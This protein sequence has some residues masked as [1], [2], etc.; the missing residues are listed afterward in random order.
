MS[1]FLKYISSHRAPALFMIVSAAIF[2]TVLYL[3]SAPAEAVLYAVLL[4]LVVAAFFCFFSYRDYRRRREELRFFV[5]DE[6]LDTDNL[7]VPRHIMEQEYTDAIISL[8]DRLRCERTEYERRREEMVDYYTVWAHQIKTPL[9]AMNLILQGAEGIDGE[10]RSE[11]LK[12]EQYVDMV[13]AYL[14]AGG[15][16]TDFLIR[17]VSLGD[18]VRASVRRLSPIFIREKISANVDIGYVRVLTD[19]KWLAFAVEQLLTNA[20]KYTPAGGMITITVQN[21]D[22]LVIADTGIGISPEDLPRIFEKG[23]TGYNGR[24]DKKATGIGLYLVKRMMTMLGHSITVN[25]TVGEGTEVR[26][27]LGSDDTVIE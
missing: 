2:V 21:G 10:M 12:T 3:Y 24:I 11:L 4:S 9:S 26:L 17:R 25:S 5:K 19:E 13:L 18:V 7:P 14:R 6:A 16:H 20:L 22:T 27:Y 8:T 15:D 23:F 1:D